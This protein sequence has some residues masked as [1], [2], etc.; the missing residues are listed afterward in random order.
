MKAAVRNYHHAMRHPAPLAAL[1]L[2][3]LPAACGP[4]ADA[5]LEVTYKV[6]GMHCGGCAEAIVA[7]VGEVKGVREVR[8]TYESGQASV[9]L[10]D[11]ASRAEAERAITKLG[12]A[13]EP[14]S[15]GAAPPAATAPQ[16]PASR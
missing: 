9:V 16:P 8:C 5:P 3:V 7:E 14:V 10:A 13:I 4:A 6:S 15:R 1:L 11:P 2:A 12:Y